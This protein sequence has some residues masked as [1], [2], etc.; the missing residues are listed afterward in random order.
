MKKNIIVICFI[1]VSGFAGCSMHDGKGWEHKGEG[2]TD[3]VT[4][5]YLFEHKH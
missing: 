3:A 5:P 2:N 1:I 4:S